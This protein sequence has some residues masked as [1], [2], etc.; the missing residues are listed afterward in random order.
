MRVIVGSSSQWF[1]AWDS[2]ANFSLY[3]RKFNKLRFSHIV[4]RGIC[5]QWSWDNKHWKYWK[6]WLFASLL[7]W[8][9]RFLASLSQLLPCCATNILLAP[10][11]KRR[12]WVSGFTDIESG[13]VSTNLGILRQTCI[14]TSQL[15]KRKK[16]VSSLKDR[17]LLNSVKRKL[18]VHWNVFLYIRWQHC[19]NLQSVL[20]WTT[21]TGTGDIWQK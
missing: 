21:T 11:S 2:W 5:R 10:C 18:L 1:L 20:M 16:C 8:D 15:F 4:M 13:R 19:F 9:S 3:I 14:A 6:N 7:G 17:L 12:P